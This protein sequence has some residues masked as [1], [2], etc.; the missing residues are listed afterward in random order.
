MFRKKNGSGPLL[1]S[2]NGNGVADDPNSKAY[3]I[4]MQGMFQGQIWSRFGVAHDPLS[5]CYSTMY[6][7]LATSYYQ[8]H[9]LVVFHCKWLLLQ[10][11]HRGR[12]EFRFLLFGWQQK[13]P[14]AELGPVSRMKVAKHACM[15][16]C[17]K[18]R[19][20]KE[21]EERWDPM[22][23]GSTVGMQVMW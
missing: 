17:P 7:L 13:P 10:Y 2:L 9:L 15:A 12:K 6:K 3:L 14:P 19:R 21:K 1:T 16:Q 8:V 4:L 5:S 11:N 20:L 18:P 22:D 23:N